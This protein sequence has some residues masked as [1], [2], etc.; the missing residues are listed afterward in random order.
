MESQ[1]ASITE[2]L[3]RFFGEVSGA[4]P[5][6]FLSYDKGIGLYRGNDYTKLNGPYYVVL[7]QLKDRK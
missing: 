6:W 1:M 3:D 7:P 4:W 5:R 2:S